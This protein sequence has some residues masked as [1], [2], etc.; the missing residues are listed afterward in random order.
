MTK[1]CKKVRHGI[2]L[3]AKEWVADV[4]LNKQ[5][6]FPSD[7]CDTDLRPDM[8]IRSQEEKILILIELT[9]PCEENLEGRHQEKEAKYE[10]LAGDCRKVGWKT[11]VFAVEVGARGYVS[12]PFI[13]CLRRLGIQSRSMKRIT[14]AASNSAL[15]CSFWIWLRK[16]DMSWSSG[17]T[18]ENNQTLPNT[19]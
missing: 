8:L 7:I 4:D 5:L 15:R 13:T 10:V 3:E 16:S 14:T 18:E 1:K 2:L 11:F 12:D 9:S 17:R 6:K 19:S